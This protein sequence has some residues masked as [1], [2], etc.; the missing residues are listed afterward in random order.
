[1]V[2]ATV[3]PALAHAPG[4]HSARCDRHAYRLWLKHYPPRCSNADPRAC[5]EEVIR[6]Q[7]IGEPEA[8]WLRVIPGCESTW[9][10]EEVEPTT[11]AA[12]LYQ[13]EPATW[14]STPFAGHDVLSAYWN[15]R[16]AAWGYQHLEHGPGEWSCT[17]ILGL[18]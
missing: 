2:A 3:S 15:T 16:G 12:G 13:F 9:R 1:V 5:V 17:A 4:C 6:L 11:H 7:R 8:H 18:G 14:S 10:P